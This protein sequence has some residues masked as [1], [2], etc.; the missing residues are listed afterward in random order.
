MFRFP[1]ERDQCFFDTL[2]CQIYI[3]VFGR[4][5]KPSMFFDFS[6]KNKNIV[7]NCWGPKN[8]ENEIASKR[9]KR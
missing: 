9:E 5:P 6:R 7:K 1:F 4:R 8:R 2:E 3:T